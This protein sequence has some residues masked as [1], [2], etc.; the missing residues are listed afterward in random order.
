MSDNLIAEEIM[1]FV[2]QFFG[3]D[4]ECA[5][6]KWKRLTPSELG[7]LSWHLSNFCGDSLQPAATE[8]SGGLK[9][10]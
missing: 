9:P 1:E 6:E 2:L 4:Y 5:I 8:Y 10:K 3:E 7:V